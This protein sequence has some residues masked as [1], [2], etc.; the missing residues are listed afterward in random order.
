MVF[1]TSNP[2]HCNVFSYAANSPVTSLDFDGTVPY[3][4]LPRDTK[5]VAVLLDALEEYRSL[6]GGK[7]LPL[8]FEGATHIENVEFIRQ[9]YPAYFAEKLAWDTFDVLGVD[10]SS[11][12]TM[13]ECGVS[14]IANKPYVGDLASKIDM[15]LQSVSASQVLVWEQPQVH[16]CI[17]HKLILKWE[18]Q[19]KGKNVIKTK[20]PSIL[21]LTTIYEFSGC[22]NHPCDQFHGFSG[23]MII[24]Y[25]TGDFKI[26]KLI[27][28]Q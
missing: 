14:L 27:E 18:T 16:E 13:I 17:R 10:S 12:G 3:T 22:A 25:S 6:S 8:F 2:T 23:V 28:A 20:V 24:T 21:S 7:E 9:Q 11:V 4:I 15:A 26:V 19:V 1:A 5:Q